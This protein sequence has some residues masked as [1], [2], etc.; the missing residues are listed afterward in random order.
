M[1]F[2]IGR[3]NT[4]GADK[5][6]PQKLAD[7]TISS[8]YATGFTYVAKA[9]TKAITGPKIE[10]TLDTLIGNERLLEICISPQRAV[11][12]LEVFSN[13]IH[14]TKASVNNIP[15]TPYYLENR[16]R[17]KLVTHYIRD[18]ANT[19]LRLSIPK[20]SV[21]ELTLY[22]AS[23][24]LLNNPLFTVPARPENN[25]PMPFVLNDAILVTKKVR[26]E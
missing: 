23:N 25:I 22:E 18:N 12:R 21:L 19:E 2:P 10:T 9:P 8:K 26:F 17:G 20:D 5:K 11:N 1:S 13:D 7:K 6:V 3:H 14:I 16:R 24:D 15:L 4:W